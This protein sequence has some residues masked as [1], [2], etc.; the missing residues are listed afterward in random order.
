MPAAA[1][2]SRWTTSD[3]V[4]QAEAMPGSFLLVGGDSEIAAASAGHLRRLGHSVAA[5]TRR[6]DRMA[7]ERPFLDLAAPLGDWEPPPG[8]AAACICAAVARLDACARDPAGSAH[9][10]V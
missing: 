3:A 10:N 8:I 1:A 9:V 5:T 4:I 6:R 2:S 7:A